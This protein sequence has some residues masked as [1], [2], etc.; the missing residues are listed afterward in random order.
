MA[1]YQRNSTI[2][3]SVALEV[4]LSKG[5]RSLYYHTDVDRI[6]TYKLRIIYFTSVEVKFA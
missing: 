4:L 6:K 3:F 5:G 2:L 1:G